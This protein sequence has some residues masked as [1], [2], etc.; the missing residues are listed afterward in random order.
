M[1]TS[2]SIQS[3]VNELAASLQFENWLEE[4]LA[5][6][7]SA[8]MTEV[9]SL[10]HDNHGRLVNLQEKQDLLLLDI[11]RQQ[12]KEDESEQDF[13]VGINEKFD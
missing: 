12:S 4:H 10:F 7:C 11:Y 2:K 5:N 3:A 13:F 6:T 1:V 9:Q 8:L